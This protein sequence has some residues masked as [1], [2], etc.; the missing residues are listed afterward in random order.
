MISPD[1]RDDIYYILIGSYPEDDTTAVHLRLL[2]SLPQTSGCRR[3]SGGSNFDSGMQT[4]V[5]PIREIYLRYLRDM[6]ERA[7]VTAYLERPVTLI[8]L[9]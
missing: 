4:V 8:L 3:L 6:A 1:D 7:E 2:N 5:L 9:I